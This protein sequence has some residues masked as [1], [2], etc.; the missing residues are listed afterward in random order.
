MISSRNWRGCGNAKAFARLLLRQR[1]VDR[2]SVA[3]GRLARTG[4]LKVKIVPKCLGVRSEQII[5]CLQLR[6][7]RQRYA[8]G[9][10]ADLALG[11]SDVI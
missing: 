8:V 10:I 7:R 2:E 11:A 5:G 4:D 6:N 9:R 1:K 3:E